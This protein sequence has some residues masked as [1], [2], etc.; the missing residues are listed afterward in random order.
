MIKIL[1]DTS[2]LKYKTAAAL[3]F[4]HKT[5]VWMKMLPMFVVSLYYLKLHVAD[6]TK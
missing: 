5:G 6:F 1:L 4:V 3:I 2:V